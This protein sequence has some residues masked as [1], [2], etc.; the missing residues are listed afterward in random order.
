V[1][2]SRWSVIAAAA[3]G[4]S[5]AAIASSSGHQ[6][7]VAAR[8]HPLEGRL[9]ELDEQLV[10]RRAPDLAVEGDVQL[11]ERRG[12]A[13]RAHPREQVGQPLHVALG[14]APGGTRRDR[15]FDRRAQVHHLAQRALV[16]RP[17]RE[18]ADGTVGGRRDERAAARPAVDEALQLELPQRLAHARARDAELDRELALGRQ[19]A[20]RGQHAVLDHLLEALGEAVRDGRGSRDEVRPVDGRRRTVRWSASP[21]ALG[22]IGSHRGDGPLAGPAATIPAPPGS[23]DRCR[24]PRGAAPGNPGD[25]KSFTFWR[26]VGNTMRLPKGD[27][28]FIMCPMLRSILFVLWGIG[29]SSDPSP[30]VI[31]G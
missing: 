31:S 2:A 23:T 14:R 20:A 7:A 17:A 27:P 24:P 26:R 3:A 11:G 19:P 15:R 1:T 18:H 12:A 30:R 25:H 9:D 13:L 22:R 6:R 21:R 28:V 5:P 29:S 10:V 4:G 8:L 16:A